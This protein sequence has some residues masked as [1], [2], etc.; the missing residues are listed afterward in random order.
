M[1]AK[2]SSKKASKTVSKTVSKKASKKTSKKASK[3]SA[4]KA[5]SRASSKA[6]DDP[7]ENPSD[8]ASAPAVE[9]SAGTCSSLDVN[10]GHVFA[11]RPRVTTSFKPG[12]FQT[13]KH[14][15]RDEKYD[16]IQKAARSVVKEALELTHGLRN[17]GRARRY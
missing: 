5:P 1:A 2:K 17:K 6:K 11:L 8:G 10:M 15:L 16:D 13:A 9:E 7:A 12:D 14:Q 3:K 4:K